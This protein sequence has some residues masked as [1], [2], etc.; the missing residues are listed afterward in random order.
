M[1][2]SA[3]GAPYDYAVSCLQ[4]A[5]GDVAALAQPLQTLL[6]VE[7]AQSMIDNGGLAYF[8]EYDFP[9]HPPYDLFVAAYRRIGAASAAECIE[10]SVGLFPFAEPELFAELRVLWLE[11]FR[12]D[13]AGAFAEFSRRIGGDESVWR[14]LDEYVE[15]NRD[16]FTAV[17]TRKETG[18]P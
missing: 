1:T 4:A 11:K 18:V 8:F 13:E 5:G 3:M 2:G 16:A 12:V 7:S 17:A 6:L 14:H 10:Q 9:N 15:R